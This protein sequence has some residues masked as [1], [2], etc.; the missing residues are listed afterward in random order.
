[1]DKID[2]SPKASIALA[3][4]GSSGSTRAVV[5]NI[6]LTKEEEKFLVDLDARVRAA[7]SVVFRASEGTTDRDSEM[8]ISSRASML[9]SGDLEGRLSKGNLGR[10]NQAESRALNVSSSSLSGAASVLT[11]K[12]QEVRSL[13]VPPEAEVDV[14]SLDKK[15]PKGAMRV[16]E[17][18]L[19]AFE[20]AGI[21]DKCADNPGAEILQKLSK[22]VDNI[23]NEIGKFGAGDGDYSSRIKKAFDSCVEKLEKEGVIK[24]G[25]EGGFKAQLNV[26]RGNCAD[27]TVTNGFTEGGVQFKEKCSVVETGSL[28]GDFMEKFL[29]AKGIDDTEG[30]VEAAKNP[31]KLRTSETKKYKSLQA[32]V[33]NLQK[34]VFYV[35][36]KIASI[37]LRSGAPCT[38]G[39]KYNGK[40]Y[41][42]DELKAL[43][44]QEVV[45]LDKL[46][47]GGT[48][49]LIA[50]QRTKVEAIQKEM[51]IRLGCITAQALSKVSASIEEMVK[52]PGKLAKAVDSGTFLHVEQSF[53][54]SL[55]P[56]ENHMIQ[57]ERDA[58]R[59][60][61]QNLKVEFGDAKSVDY[62][63]DGTIVL[64]LKRPE[65]GV[66]T[67]DR[68][69]D[70][71]V[72]LFV[73]GV[74]EQQA[75]RRPL[76]A[77]LKNTLEHD[78]NTESHDAL[79]GYM[80]KSKVPDTLEMIT[81]L[82]RVF[83]P[84]KERTFQD[85]ELVQTL[86]NFTELLGGVTG[87]NCKS[88]KDRT[89]MVFCYLQAQ[90]AIEHFKSRGGEMKEKA[91]AFAE[92]V[93]E[94]LQEG[95]SHYITGLNTGVVGYAFS[96]L[97]RLFLPSWFKVKAALCGK[98][99]S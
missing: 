60:I 56:K 75:I 10:V 29:K 65:G 47:K 35:G 84:G 2:I 30:L 61:T 59:N 38:H 95:V 58:F 32:V 74:N 24:G 4:T 34:A 33:T 96:A 19:A 81:E 48:S 42:M 50:A 90:K 43:E 82:D 99:P 55:E 7:G 27:T 16:L 12:L 92:K 78:I 25:G 89:S 88:G 73:Q 31:P 64:T 6:Q 20:A 80:F 93:Q 98:G 23:F 3:N 8:S 52:D 51:D 44:K 15:T 1:M 41:S 11:T 63:D 22:E 83:A 69:F 13:R 67:A 40:K 28:A 76:P 49:T 39:R 45:K 71:L 87:I 79:R 46:E 85:G 86:Q 54:S 37:T 70:V 57:E 53:L 91:V 66:L 14:S 72:P 26:Q 97:Q 21:G 17:V 18:H 5:G 36:D 68:K 77:V 62:Q 9:G 94:K